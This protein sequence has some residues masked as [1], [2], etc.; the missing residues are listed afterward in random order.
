ML[1]LV[2]SALGENVEKSLS[3]IIQTNIQQAVIPAIADTT[4]ATVSTTLD[5]KLSDTVTRQLHHTIPPLLN[6]ALPE[7]ISRGVQNPDV[8][9]LLSEQLTTK[10]TNHVDR[11]F[12][13]ALQKTIVPSFQSVVVNIAQKV[14][15]EAEG[16]MKA[17]AQQAETQHRHDS[18]KIDQL[19]ELVRGLSETVHAMAGAQSEF[20]QEILKLQ[21]QV[22]QDRRKESSEGSRRSTITPK[23]PQ[24]EALDSVADLIRSGS[25]EEGT[26]QNYIYDGFLA[27]L[28]PAY[29]HELSPLLNLS[30]CAAVTSSLE[31]NLSERLSWLESAL[32]TI[33]PG[34]PELHD[35][36][37]RIMEVLR[38]RLE[39]G[40]MQISLAN[41]GEPALRRIP[42]LAH[43]T[44]EFSRH[45]R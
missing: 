8:L 25:Y 6:L 1:R 5:Q 35:V 37:A 16:R 42:P 36:G 41:P 24:Q 20:Q 26:F 33:N 7:A 29:L 17:Q 38:E 9:R 28:D 19:T 44:R 3:R 21:Q 27:R 22:M 23:T 15:S 11:E 40:F 45:F 2:S 31:S 39:S 34:D 18:T 4:S 32:A 10:I 12:S 43:Q 14:S 30:V 13:T